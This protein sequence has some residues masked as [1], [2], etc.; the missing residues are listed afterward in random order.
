M[1]HK[2]SSKEM[3]SS[4]QD[5]TTL[6]QIRGMIMTKQPNDQIYEFEGILNV[7]NTNKKVSL[8]YENFLL[9]G[10]SL[11]NTDWIYGIVTYTGHDTRIMKNSVKARA[12]FSKLER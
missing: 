7:G 6:S 10:S 1:K 9:R 2:A 4:A 3:L 11:R 5:E 8:S 12:K